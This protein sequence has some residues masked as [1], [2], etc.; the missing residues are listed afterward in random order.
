MNKYEDQTRTCSDCGD[1]FVWTVGEQEFF[2]E[3]GFADPPKRCKTC[4]QA[5]KADREQ[6][7][8]R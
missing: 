3:K 5:C 7:G 1:E 8:G 6:R 4:R 2:H